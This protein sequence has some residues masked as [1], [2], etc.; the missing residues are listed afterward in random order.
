MCGLLFLA[1]EAAQSIETLHSRVSRAMS[2]LRHRGPDAQRVLMGND[3]VA[4]HTRLA[5]IDLAG[6]QQPKQDSDKRHT[7][8]FNGEI[9][10]YRELRHRIGSAWDFRDD[11]D[12]EVLIAGLVLYGSAFIDQLD[13]MWAFAFYDNVTGSLLLSRDRFGKKPLYYR[14]TER[15]FMCA[16]ELPAL[17]ELLSGE[18]KEDI[19]SISDYFRY[20]YTLPGYTCYDGIREVL[21]GHWLHRSISG[22]LVTHRYW[23]PVVTRCD[24]S[25]AEAVEQVREK[26]AAAVLRRQLAADVEVGAFLSGG[27]DSTIVCALAQPLGG[28]SIRTFTVGFDESS[29]DERGHAARAAKAIGSTHHSEVVDAVQA[30]SFARDIPQ[31]I[32]HPFGD[33]SL[34]PT[35]MVAKLASQHVKVVLTGDGA[36]EVFG[37]YARYAGRMLSQRFHKAPAGVRAALA[38]A[39]RSF[40]E[41]VHHH[42]G[43]LLKKAHLF[44][45]LADEQHRPYIAPRMMGNDVFERL[46]PALV[47]RG[48][49]LP[50]PPWP[51]DV[52]GIRQMIMMDWLVYLPQDILA[53]VDRATMASSVEARSPFLDRELV[54][55][56][57][58]LPSQWHFK[59][60][61][62]KQLLRQA[63]RGYVPDFIWTRRKQGFASPVGHWLRGQFGE[64]LEQMLRAQ[65]STVFMPTEA[66]RLLAEH[67][68]GKADHTQPL[69][70]VHSYLAWHQHVSVRWPTM[71]VR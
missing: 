40:P 2:L 35:A 6:G 54:E 34:V 1:G 36:D 60:Y 66:R 70:L 51:E 12:T 45:K 64:E 9:Y 68:A 63:M 26:L 65:G 19:D 58:R 69:W 8:V 52:D 7:L 38:A 47:D 4:G 50:A 28:N 31:M 13:G 27:V 20:G 33:A 18:E 32:G 29:F 56:V 62:G 39:V 37:G 24:M 21:P 3:F 11:S 59:G 25:R 10:N 49:R 46:L 41:P 17:I 30:V 48:H 71:A 43:S 22:E 67:R 16:S 55:F 57:L 14:H 44:L 42:S 15:G 23:T 53:K 5:I 61:R